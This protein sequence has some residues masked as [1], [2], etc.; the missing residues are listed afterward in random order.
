MLSM[1][2]YDKVNIHT[3]I[4]QQTLTNSKH[5]FQVPKKPSQT[6]P[7]HTLSPQKSITNFTQPDSQFPRTHYKLHPVRLSVPK[8]PSQTSPSQTLSPQNYITN[9][10][11]SYSQSPKIYYK[12]HTHTVIPQQSTKNFTV[13]YIMS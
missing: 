7:S 4:Q 5:M 1:R 10:T 11:Q 6:S 9:F 12:I 2:I 13:T 8:N 3:S